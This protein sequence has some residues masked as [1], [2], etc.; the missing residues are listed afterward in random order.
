MSMVFREFESLSEHKF[1]FDL[2][3]VNCDWSL[4]GV[5]L[6]RAED[7]HMTLYVA[8]NLEALVD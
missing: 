8:R 2:G 5:D 3:T 4:L 1:K 7:V 6:E